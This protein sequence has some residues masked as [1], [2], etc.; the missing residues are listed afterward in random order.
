MKIERI[1]LCYPDMDRII[2]EKP[3]GGLI[4]DA[5]SR[6]D[7]SK[8]TGLDVTVSLTVEEFHRL[9]GMG[10]VILTSA[11]NVPV[12]EITTDGPVSAQ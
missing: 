10:Q 9:R 11:S 12:M 5:L 7:L 6:F 8:V 2:V 1:I 4:E 3:K